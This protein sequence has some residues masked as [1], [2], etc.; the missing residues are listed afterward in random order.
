MKFGKDAPTERASIVA[1]LQGT[2]FAL[3][4]RH[5][6]KFAQMSA[7]TIRGMITRILDE[8]HIEMLKQEHVQD[9]T[10]IEFDQ[11]TSG[12]FVDSLPKPN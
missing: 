6:D 9:L 11:L 3:R 8:D 2:Y 4:N 12:I 10:R 5:D 7:G 1:L